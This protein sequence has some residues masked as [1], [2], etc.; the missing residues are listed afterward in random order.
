MTTISNSSAFLRRVL[1]TDAA[2]GALAGIVLLFAAAPL[3]DILALP[4]PLLRY[5]GLALLPVAAFILYVATRPQPPRAAVWAIIAINAAWTAESIP[6]LFSGWI[7]PTVLGQICVVAQALMV[8]GFA[9]FEFIGLR[10]S[11]LRRIAI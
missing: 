10:R 3:A 6:L 7:H 8:A 9:E 1:L 4:A 11:T 5:A 2:V